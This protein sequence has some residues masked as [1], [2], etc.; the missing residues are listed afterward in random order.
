MLL[1]FQ[2]MDAA[3]KDGVIK[4]VM[5]GVNLQ[6]CQVCSFKVPSAEELDHD[7]LWRTT[8]RLPERGRIGIFNRSYYEEVLVVRVPKE[9]FEDI[10]TFERYLARDG[11]VIRKFLLNLSKKE[12]KR[13]FLARLDE[14]E[15]NW[16]FS[17]ADINERASW[18]ASM[19]A[20]EDMIAHTATEKAPWYIVPSDNKWFTRVVVA[21]AIVDTPENLQLAYP[22]V[23][24]QKRKEANAARKLVRSKD[25]S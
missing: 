18:D 11:I 4:H 24:P 16:K 1:I 17:A 6:G 20:D 19:A 23:N 10:R 5:S 22:E 2:A 7:F 12:Q 15:K 9:R 3:G 13:R 14:P 25:A 8:T 21:A